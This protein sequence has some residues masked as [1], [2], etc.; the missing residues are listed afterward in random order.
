MV[1]AKPYSV[2]VVEDDL[3]HMVLIQIA[4]TQADANARIHVSKSAEEAI[5]YIEGPRPGADFGRGRV[6]NIIV[7]DMGM[8]GMGGLGFLEWY[9][10]KSKIT[11][12]PVVVFT[13]SDD[14]D[15]AR[16]CLALGAKEFKDKSQD[17]GELVSVV[18]RV[19]DRW[20][21]DA[22]GLPGC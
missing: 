11:D 21:P 22:L 5:E 3:N 9:S 4:F 7:L 20:P 15:L 14:Q 17:F 1:G 6:P 18:Q 12:V 16:Q 13:S 2:L 8:P 19:L 10:G